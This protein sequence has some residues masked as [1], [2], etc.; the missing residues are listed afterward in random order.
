M[1]HFRVP[2]MITINCTLDDNDGG[3]DI[4][5]NTWMRIS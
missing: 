2:E 4:F 1:V 3:T 5:S